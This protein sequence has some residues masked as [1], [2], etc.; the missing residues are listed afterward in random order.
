MQQKNLTP[1]LSRRI[2]GRLQWTYPVQKVRFVVIQSFLNV[3]FCLGAGRKANIRTHFI[4]TAFLATHPVRNTLGSYPR[5][6]TR[7]VM[8][9]NVFQDRGVF[10]NASKNLKW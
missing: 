6:M 2:N 8:P 10:E 4:A 1:K 3:R 7:R 5:R 9:E